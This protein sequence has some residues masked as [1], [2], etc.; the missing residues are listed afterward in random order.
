LSQKVDPNG[1]HVPFVNVAH[2]LSLTVF[3]GAVLIVDLRLLGRGMRKEPLAQ[4]AEDARPWLIGGFAAM[5]VTGALQVLAT[6][7]KAYFSDQFWLKMQLIAVAVVFT[8]TIRRMITQA[9]ERRVGPIWGKLVG[10]T[11][12]TLWAYI[13]A[14]GRLIGLL[15]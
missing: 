2:L 5:A 10:L 3:V 12:I 15:Q 14:Q 13:A 4:V 7:L 6:P 8:F 9:D 11:S 1:Y